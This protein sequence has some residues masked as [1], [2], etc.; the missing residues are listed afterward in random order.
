V[1]VI[2]TVGERDTGKRL[3]AFLHERLAEFSRTRLQ[4][5]IKQERV[6]V[7]GAPARA[8]QILRGRE[9]I[10][11]EPADLTPLK[12]EAEELPLEILYEDRNVVVVNKAAGMVVHAGAGRSRGTLVNALLHHFG[13][14]SSI[15]GALRPGIVHRLDRETSGVLII[16]RT[17]AA[18]QALSRQFHD[19]EVEKSYLAL[20]HGK[21]KHPHGRIDTPISRDPVRRIRMTTKLV[22][23]RAALTEYR[24]LEQ[25]ERFSY[26]GVRIGT[27]R[28]H[29]IRVHLASLHHP[30]L[31][32][33]LY[34]A[35]HLIG[36]PVLHDRFFLHAHRL[37]FRSP[38]TGEWI[39]IESALPRELEACLDVLRQE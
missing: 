10:T 32:D 13:S 26:L 19:R 27:G 22:T 17:D 24:V 25:F 9:S 29:Q 8:S 18:H 23:G 34:G 39:S 11:V 14:L 16:A 12:A 20:V 38:S 2:L 6:L 5:W 4:S 30:I 21:M 36:G 31:G 28:T 35:P 7:E 37:R 15:N 3:D 33:R 1:S